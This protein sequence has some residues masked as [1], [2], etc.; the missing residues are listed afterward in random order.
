MSTLKFSVVLPTCLREELL[1]RCLE[2][3][4]PGVQQADPQS[5]EVIVTDGAQ[6]QT[7]EAMMRAHFPWARWVKGPSRGP[8]ANRNHGARKARGEWICFIDDDWIAG[9]E[10]IN[11]YRQGCGGGKIDLMEGR[12]TVP[13]MTDNPFAHSVSNL[14]G[15][16]YWSCNLAVRR[17]R[18]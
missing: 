6:G 7:A 15:G 4:R 13:D 2:S 1:A 12:T 5:Y 10:L 3:L 14:N 11:A 17:E 9:Q 18:F 8:A 16:S